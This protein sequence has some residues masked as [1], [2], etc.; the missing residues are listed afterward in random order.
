MTENKGNGTRQRAPCW[1]IDCKAT[2]FLFEQMLQ[3]TPVIWLHLCI[4]SV[5]Y[6]MILLPGIL[7]AMGYLSS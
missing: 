1:M 2:E 4:F 6:S 5:F 3:Q 7:G